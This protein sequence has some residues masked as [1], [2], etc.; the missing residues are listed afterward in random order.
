MIPLL[1]LAIEAHGG[2]T[3]WSRLQIVDLEFNVGGALWQAKG[4]PAG[5]RAAAN[6]DL[7][8]KRVRIEPFDGD[9]T[10]GYFTPERVWVEY[11]NGG[12]MQE[13][14]SPRSSFIGHTML[15]PW[16]KL[17]ELY[18][19]GYALLNDLSAPFMFADP[20]FEAEEIE[21]RAE[22]DEIWRRMLVRFPAD[23][24]T[25]SQEQTFYFN[26]QG[27]L[28]RINYTADIAQAPAAHYCFDHYEVAGI[29]VPTYRRVFGREARK[30]DPEDL[31]APAGVELRMTRIQINRKTS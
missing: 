13:R 8:E 29:V 17:H 19:A 11:A 15:T 1:E 9:G 31:A 16:D 20:G 28:K 2:L 14:R 21:P 12:V 6:V 5:L 25:H 3:N 10:I 26:E 22:N 7:S 23:F 27:L 30:E 4:L 24:P 18:F